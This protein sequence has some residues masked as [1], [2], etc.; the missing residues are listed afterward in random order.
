MWFVEVNQELDM[1]P[2]GTGWTVS[3]GPVW[4]GCQSCWPAFGGGGGGTGGTVVVNVQT[5]G[6]YQF[7]GGKL[8][9]SCPFLVWSED[10]EMM[11]VPML[12]YNK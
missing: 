10:S 12:Q 9:P 6:F 4:L 7:S 2:H 11:H 5:V 1:V 8:G 3:G